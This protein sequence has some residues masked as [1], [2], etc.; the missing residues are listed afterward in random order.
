[1]F[2][3]VAQKLRHRLRIEIAWFRVGGQ[4]AKQGD[5]RLR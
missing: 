1:M 5:D 4:T 2:L 3:G